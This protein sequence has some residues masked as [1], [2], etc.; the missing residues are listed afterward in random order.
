M[1]SAFKYAALAVPWLTLTVAGLPFQTKAQDLVFLSTQLRQVEE[2]QKMRDILL[3]GAPKTSFVVDE[4]SAFAERLKSEFNANNHKVSL[5]GALHG[6]LQALS[7]LGALDA[8]DDLADELSARH[9]PAVLIEAGRFGGSKQLYIP[10][11]Q[12]TYVFVVKKDALPFLPPNADLNA[13]SY[14]QL[15]QWAK[16]IAENTGQRRLGFPAGTKGLFAR[17]LQGYLYPSYT[18]SVVSE[19]R[20]A[21]AAKM[22]SDFKALWTSVN[23][24]SAKYDFMQDPLQSGEVW[25]AWDH[26][27]R[28]KDALQASPGDYQIIA[29]P[30]GPKGR[31]YMSVVV[32]LSILKNA[33]DR[34]GAAA[35]IQHLLKPETQIATAAETGFLPVVEANLLANSSPGIKLLAEGFHKTQSAKDGLVVMLPVGLGDKADEFDKVFTDT[36]QQIVLRGEPVQA[37]LDAQARAM[38]DIFNTTKAVCWVPDQPSDGPCPVK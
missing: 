36:F 35:V 17:F 21:D 25:I 8:I 12:A 3:K 20:S 9:I 15:A 19:F 13:L 26:I 6:E 33:P 38:R 24:K 34:A 16:T 4:P 31:A 5:V 32:G 23:P 37:T 14:D 10:W 2:A 29:P 30:M 7:S 18:G 22:W 28:F 27:A 11:M 1:L